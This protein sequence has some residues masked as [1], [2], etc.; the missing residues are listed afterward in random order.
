[1]EKFTRFIKTSN[2]SRL[3]LAVAAACILVSCAPPAEKKVWDLVWP[4]PPEEPKIKFVETL[5]SNLDV[6]VESGVAET[7]FG[8]EVI[9]ILKPYGVAADKEGR[10]YVTDVGGIYVFDKKNKKFS[11]IGNEPGMGNLEAPAGI[12]VSRADGKIYVTDINL[13]RIVIYDRDGN[14][15]N[16]IG[17]EKEF[18]NPIGIAVD[19]KRMRVYVVDSKKRNVR[20]YTLDGRL[21]MEINKT[22]EGQNIFH[23]PT[24]IALDSEGKIYVSDTQGFSVKIFNPEGGL[25]RSM[26]QLGDAFGDFARPKG[27]AINSED[28]LYVVDA[29]YNNFQI[30]NKEGQLLLFVG[31][32]GSNPGEFLLPA[33]IAVDDEDRIYVAE[34]Y[35]ARVQVFQYLGEKW[36]KS[37]PDLAEEMKNMQPV[38]TEGPVDKE[39]VEKK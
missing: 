19:D 30:F 32:G 39:A 29:A 9:R 11:S 35:N 4:L 16:F 34:Q 3:L 31:K 26:G 7:L 25:V 13:K 18:E 14:F 1:M 2:S 24:E 36:K 15:L 17:K 33:G 28:H 21:I 27:V 20:A 37:H 23:T 6:E 12:A 38:R 10:V 5:Q 8:S 22:G